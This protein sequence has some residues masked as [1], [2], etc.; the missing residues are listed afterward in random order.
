MLS[1]ALFFGSVTIAQEPAHGIDPKRHPNLR[2]AQNDMVNAFHHI[3]AAQKDNDFDMEGHAAK[4]KDLLV[5]ASN[6]LREAAEIANQRHKSG[7]NSFSS[8]SNSERIESAYHGVKC[9]LGLDW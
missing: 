6:E 1:T 8:R 2:A 9:I 5:Q 7:D 4:A 3:D